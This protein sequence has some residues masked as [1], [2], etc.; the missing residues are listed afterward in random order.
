MTKVFLLSAGS[1]SMRLGSVN[2]VMT[3]LWLHWTLSAAAV[4][5]MKHAVII[6]MAGLLA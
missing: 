4:N 6:V 2:A 3:L 5:T 1:M